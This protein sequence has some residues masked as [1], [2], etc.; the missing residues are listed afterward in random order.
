MKPVKP[1]S[2][3]GPD[4]VELIVAKYQP[5]YIPLPAN[6]IYPY[7]E[8]KWKMSFL[9]RLKVLFTGQVYLVLKTFGKPISPIILR[10]NRTNDLDDR[11]PPI[12]QL[13]LTYSWN[14]YCDS[15]LTYD[16]RCNK[17]NTGWWEET[18]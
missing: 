13:G 18:I 14:S 5:Q 17:C 16:V 9:E 11:R 8:T 10:V 4:V 15:H 1:E 12:P 7:V 6:I 3:K 2:R